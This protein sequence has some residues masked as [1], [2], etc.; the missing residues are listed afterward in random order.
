MVWAI[1]ILAVMN[2]ATIITVLYNRNQTRKEI[3]VAEYEPAWIRNYVNKIQ[4]TLVS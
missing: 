3:V 1:V 2:I 4:R